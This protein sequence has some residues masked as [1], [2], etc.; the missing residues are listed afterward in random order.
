MAVFPPFAETPCFI[1]ARYFI[2]VPD[3]LSLKPGNLWTPLCL[4]RGDGIIKQPDYR[5]EQDPNSIANDLT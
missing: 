3:V 2:D 1:Q 4:I 5:P